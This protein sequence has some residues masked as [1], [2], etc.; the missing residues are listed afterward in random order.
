MTALTNLLS[1]KVDVTLPET[2]KKWHL[3]TYFNDML[4]NLKQR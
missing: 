4:Q 3:K 1:L 2:L